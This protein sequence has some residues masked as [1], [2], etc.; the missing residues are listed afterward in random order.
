[1]HIQSAL[2]IYPENPD[3]L[4]LYADLL[5][6]AYKIGFSGRPELVDASFAAMEKAGAVD[7]NN[8]EMLLAQALFALQQGDLETARNSG[9]FVAENS[10]NSGLWKI[11]LW[12]HTIATDPKDN[13][14]NMDWAV[15]GDDPT[16]G[17]MHLPRFLAYY[18][19]GEYEDALG[20]AISFGMPGVF[21]GPLLRAAALAQ[22]GLVKA[23][24]SELERLNNLN[25]LFT[26]NPIWYLQTYVP[27]LHVAEH[28]QEGLELA[29]LRAH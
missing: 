2:K 12:M 9:K 28:M 19:S 27:Q 16:P 10:G 24:G 5:L 18:E 6:D 8:M 23:A 11:G 3:L 25:P 22:L 20:A 14:Q 7:G 13:A 26:D 15:F 4:S 17:W 21:W 1:M 29:G